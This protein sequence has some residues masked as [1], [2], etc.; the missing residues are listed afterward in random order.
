[1]RE[2]R[3]EPQEIIPETQWIRPDA[4]EIRP[5]I[6]EIRPDTQKRYDIKINIKNQRHRR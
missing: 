5:E 3:R 4:Q 1:M 6:Q 2:D